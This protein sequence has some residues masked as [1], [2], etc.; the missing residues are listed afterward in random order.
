ETAASGDGVP[1]PRIVLPHPAP[2]LTAQ[3]SPDGVS[4]L[5][6]A[7]DGTAQLWDAATGEARGT[8]QRNP[9]AV[10][11]AAVAPDGRTVATGSVVRDPV[12]P[13]TTSGETRL[14]DAAT[15]R[16]V[17]RPLSHPGRVT[18]LTFSPD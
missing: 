11:A 6:G 12:T 2:V 13:Q 9:G 15:G 4:V 3:F 18:A 5:T 17:G 1:K 8:P 16:Q 14:W 7:L 10:V